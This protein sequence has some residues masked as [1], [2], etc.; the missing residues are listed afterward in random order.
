[1]IDGEPCTIHMHEVAGLDEATD[2][3]ICG[4]EGIVCLYN[5]ALRSSYERIEAIHD[6]IQKIKAASTPSALDPA[7]SPAASLPPFQMVLVGTVH[8]GTEREVSPKE[9]NELARKLGCEFFEV[10]EATV[11]DMLHRIIR[12]C[13]Q[14]RRAQARRAQGSNVGISWLMGCVGGRKS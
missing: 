1:M 10:S 3:L 11:E 4:A 13:R 5:V 2:R 9:G 8:V 12:L 6:K 14:A 7:T